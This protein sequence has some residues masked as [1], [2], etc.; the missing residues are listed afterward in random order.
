MSTRRSFLILAAALAVAACSTMQT[1]TPVTPSRAFTSDQISVATR[2]S[3]PDVILIHGLGGHTNLWTESADALDERFRLHLVQ[4]RGFGGAPRS[5]SD[6]LV[7]GTAR[8]VARYIRESALTRPAV[9]GHSLGGTVAMMVAARN[10]GLAGRVMV[11]DMVPF[12]GVMFGQPDA[13]VA[14][15]R[16]MADQMHAGLLNTD[17]FH[18]MVA[19]MT[20]GEANRQTVLQ[21]VNASDRRV[22]AD[23]MRELILTDMRPELPRLTLPLTV[24]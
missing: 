18:Q 17:M 7:S 14:T 24:L 23:A 5:S 1:E 12:M 15:L 8:E 19:T 3:G 16:P 11:V 4:I 13:T 20:R 2:G 10:P 22:M 6:S 9:I 21:Y